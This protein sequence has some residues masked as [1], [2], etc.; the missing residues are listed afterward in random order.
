M[1][2]GIIGP[3]AAKDEFEDETPGGHPEDEK[4]LTP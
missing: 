2:R 3:D 4:R 1:K